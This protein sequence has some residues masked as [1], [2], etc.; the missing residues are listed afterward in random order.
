[1]RENM[2][3]EESKNMFWGVTLDG[4]MQYTQVVE[5]AFH[6]SMAAVEPEL[7][8]EKLKQS[9]F[10]SLMLR[11]NKAEFLICTLEHNRLLQ[12]PL[13]LNFSQGEHVSFYL[14][15]SGVVHLTGYLLDDDDNID[16]SDTSSLESIEEAEIE[17]E[18]LGKRKK[19]GQ[20]LG[21]NKKVKVEMNEDESSEEDE[22]DEEENNFVD[23]EDEDEE[24]D[25]DEDQKD[26]VT[27]ID[28]SSDS[29][30][31]NEDTSDEKKR[32]KD[33]TK[34]KSKK[35]PVET[36]NKSLQKSQTPSTGKKTKKQVDSAN[37][38]KQQTPNDSVEKPQKRVLDG[39]VTS[40][41]VKMGHGPEAKAGKMVH[42][43]Y[44]GRVKSSGKLFDSNVGSRPFKFR[45]GKS[46][47]IKGWDVGLRGMK[48]GGKRKLTVPPTM[49][50]GSQRIGPIPPNSTL[51]F[52]VELK[53]VS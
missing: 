12:Q 8:K 9:R 41:D 48:V 46:E 14:S 3:E 25:D 15:G 27:R 16:L 17:D 39:N 30:A 47:V 2:V 6:V 19:T 22:D 13:E 18:R 1:M 44:S 42:V 21:S 24:A 29:S 32:K 10:V 49:G 45:L 11:H 34:K 28:F 23:E 20:T 53:A 40:E 51:M 26:I 4:G 35:Q 38:T 37:N 7:D 36:P 52:E 50:Y 43:Y 5:H 31:D 33:K